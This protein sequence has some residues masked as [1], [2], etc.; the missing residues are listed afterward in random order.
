[1]C[2]PQ[3]IDFPGSLLM[4]GNDMIQLWTMRNDLFFLTKNEEEELAHVFCF[5]PSCSLESL[6]VEEP[7]CNPQIHILRMLAQK[8]EGP[9]SLMT[10]LTPALASL[11]TAC[12]TRSTKSYL[13]NLS[14]QVSSMQTKAVLTDE[15]SCLKAALSIL[16]TLTGWDLHL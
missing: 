6:G 5:S 1:M 13:L 11:H 4:R 16:I 3:N 14:T 8:I 12:Y 7:T 10:P 15:K 2:P 9:V